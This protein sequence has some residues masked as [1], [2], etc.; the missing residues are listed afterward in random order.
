MHKTELENKEKKNIYEEG[1][2][3]ILRK[4]NEEDR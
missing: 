3:K 2:P 4:L 1:Y